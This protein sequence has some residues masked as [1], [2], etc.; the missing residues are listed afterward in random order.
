DYGKLSTYRS[1]GGMG[2]RL[3][4][5]TFSGAVIT[6]FYDSLLVKVT[7][8]GLEFGAAARRMMRALQEFRV[9]GVKTNIPFLVNLV[10]HPDFLAYRVTTRFIDETRALFLLPRR[11]DRATKLLTYIAEVIVNGP[12]EA[13]GPPAP[14]RSRPR[15]RGTLTQG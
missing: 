14:G 4:G 8:Q 3:D 6:P 15:P 5:S 7:A 11:Q 9:R 1:A 2:I 12:L 10:T 13:A